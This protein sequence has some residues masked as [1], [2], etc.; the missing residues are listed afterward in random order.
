MNERSTNAISKS[1]I[2]KRQN[3]ERSLEHEGEKMQNLN[4]KS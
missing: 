2:K 4:K 1:N 3:G